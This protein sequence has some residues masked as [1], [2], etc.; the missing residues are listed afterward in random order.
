MKKTLYRFILPG[1]TKVKAEPEG[2]DKVHLFE[3]GFD[4]AQNLFA[5]R[6]GHAV[7]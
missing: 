1:S 3:V 6:A 2:K 7:K 4:F 5:F